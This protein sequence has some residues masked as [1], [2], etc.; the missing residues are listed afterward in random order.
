[1]SHFS[2]SNVILHNVNCIKNIVLTQS[3]LTILKTSNRIEKEK[4]KNYNKTYKKI[5]FQLSAETY[6]SLNDVCEKLNITKTD[7]IKQELEGLINE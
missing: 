2:P 1:L 7:L 4:R 5:G 3:E 6:Q